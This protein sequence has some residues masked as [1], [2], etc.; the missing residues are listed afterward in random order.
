MNQLYI[1][2][3]YFANIKKNLTVKIFAV[4][5][6]KKNTINIKFMKLSKNKIL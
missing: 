1:S 4:L 5:K 2:H 6:C 3:N